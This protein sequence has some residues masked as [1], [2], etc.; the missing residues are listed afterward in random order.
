MKMIPP[1]KNNLPSR[2]FWKVCPMILQQEFG[3]S[4]VGSNCS[5]SIWTWGLWVGTLVTKESKF[6]IWLV[7][8]IVPCTHYTYGQALFTWV[9]TFSQCTF[10]FF[11]LVLIFFL[12]LWILDHFIF[13]LLNS[14]RLLLFLSLIVG[15]V[16]MD[17]LCVFTDWL[18]WSKLRFSCGYTLLWYDILLPHWDIYNWWQP[19]KGCCSVIIYSKA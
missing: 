17:I 2:H 16:Q 6:P 9:P 13:V 7:R 12:G 11:F 5:N 4:Y 10:S 15:V 18:T 1:I 19:G 3:N 8:L 14:S